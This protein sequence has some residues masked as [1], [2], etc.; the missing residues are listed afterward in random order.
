[1]RT[2]RHV[3]G[4]PV[5]ITVAAALTL[6]VVTAHGGLPASGGSM[7]NEYT[8]DG[9]WAAL[10]FNASGTL[11]VTKQIDVEYLIVGGGGGGAGR[12]YTRTGGGGGGR[13]C[14]RAVQ[15]SP[16]RD[17]SDHTV[18]LCTPGQS[19]YK[20]KTQEIIKSD[21]EMVCAKDLST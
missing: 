20:R 7:T 18:A 5:V 9:K 8:A 6:A 15:D 1:M 14:C 21:E 2:G 13:G 3:M 12:Y 16:S 19:A 10:I 4:V 11:T 17:R